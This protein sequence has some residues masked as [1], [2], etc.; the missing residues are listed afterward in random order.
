MAGSLSVRPQ[1]DASKHWSTYLNHILTY[2]AQRL[3]RE[4]LA[5]ALLSDSNCLNRQI[6]PSTNL[7]SD[8]QLYPKQASESPDAVSQATRLYCH[9]IARD[10]KFRDGR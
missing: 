2:P 1:P 6:R 5:F 3:L 9:S 8:S 4:T 7:R 10:E